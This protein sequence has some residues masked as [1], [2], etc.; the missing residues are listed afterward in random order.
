MSD[1]NCKSSVEHH[2]LSQND[3][4]YNAG[5]NAHLFHQLHNMEPTPIHHH[6][7][8]VFLDNKKYLKKDLVQAFGGTMNPGW[9]VPSI[10]KF[11]N[12]A[13]LGLSGFAYCTFV[14]SLINCGAKNVHIENINNGTGMFYGGLVQLIAGLW[15]ISLEN[16]FG[17]L[18]FCSFG[19]MWMA[20]AAQHIPWFNINQ[21]YTN[22]EELKNAMGIYYLGWVMLTIILLACTIK[23]TLAFF[24]LFVLVFV[25]LLLLSLCNLY[26]SDA[27]EKA[28]GVVGVL[29][30]VLAW[31]HAYAGLATPQN[32]YY[33]VDPIPMPGFGNK[34]NEKEDSDVDFEPA[35]S[36][37]V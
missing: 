1:E 36:D 20:S 12:P 21:A 22:T 16:A 3:S 30:A 14:A 6:G 7:E 13:P 32:S 4:N 33:V 10:H 5:V 25:R 34:L 37:S 29:A 18:A 9:A 28:A 31:Y 23:S 24:S 15:E 11:G 17:G 35:G 27:I 26:D 19:G 8:Y 2:E